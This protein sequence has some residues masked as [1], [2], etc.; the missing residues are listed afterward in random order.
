VSHPSSLEYITLA[1]TLAALSSSNDVIKRLA[2]LQWKSLVDS[3]ASSANSQFENC[4]AIADVSGSMGYYGHGDKKNPQPINVCLALT[5]L[6]GEL[7]S[8]PWNGCFFTFSSDP[9]CQ[10]VDPSKPLSERAAKVQGAHW[11]MSTNFY[12]VFDLILATAKREKLAPENM[13]KK[14]FIFSDMQFDEAVDR[15]EGETEHRTIKRKFEEAG[16]TL[17]ELVYWNLAARGHGTAKPARAD[18]E[19]VALVSG[20]S[21]ALMK[22][23]LGQQA[24]QE[25]EELAEEM[26]A[27]WE[28]VDEEESEEG[29][30][31]VGKKRKNGDGDGDVDEG[32]AKKTKKKKKN[33]LEVVKGII[34]AKSFEGVV[35]VD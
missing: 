13:V 18:E 19:S 24:E 23:F 5:L 32:E 20:Y 26:Q 17:P 10:F 9:A 6:L 34:G 15:Q 16:Y 8:A 31:V 22:Y 25:D 7:A 28:K 11:E 21:G 35:M 1:L 4:L 30:E 3:I 12:K 2:D 29:T 27:D 33:P 14:L